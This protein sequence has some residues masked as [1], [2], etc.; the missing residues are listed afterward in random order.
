MRFALRRPFVRDADQQ[1]V[2]DGLVLDLNEL[3]QWFSWG[4]G[5]P[6]HTPTGRQIY[7][8]RDG[9]AGTTLYAWSGAAWNA[10]A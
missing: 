1:A 2:N 9:G 5:A 10:F 4:N 7:F 8:R 3:A 6:T